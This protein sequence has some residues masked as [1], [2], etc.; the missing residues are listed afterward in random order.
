MFDF[1]DRRMLST[2]LERIHRRL[3]GPLVPGE[4][5]ILKEFQREIAEYYAGHLEM[6]KTP[7]HLTGSPFQ[8]RVWQELQRIPYG[9]TISYETLAIRI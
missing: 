8:E 9:E 1:N 4:H 5:P 7:V 3:P 6:F 2:N